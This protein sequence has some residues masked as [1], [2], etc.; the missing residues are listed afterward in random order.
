MD[1]DEIETHVK[2]ILEK[3]RSHG[4]SWAESK[5]EEATRMMFKNKWTFPDV[6]GIIPTHGDKIELFRSKKIPYNNEI[7]PGMDIIYDENGES[8]ERYT[9]IIE[10]DMDWEGFRVGYSMKEGIIGLFFPNY[11]MIK[12]GIKKTLGDDISVYFV[13]DIEI[14]HVP[15]HRDRAPIYEWEKAPNEYTSIDV[16]AIERGKFIFADN[17]GYE[18]D[19]G[20]G[21]KTQTMVI[22]SG[23]YVATRFPYDTKK[24]A[25]LIKRPQEESI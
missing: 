7:I 22:F 23:G 4:L 9:E 2:G 13:D 20:F 14:F 11:K 21:P 16:E 12:R 10:P 1:K 5:L 17:R 18:F 19:G 25:H 15:E 24:I 6:R 3:A 8:W